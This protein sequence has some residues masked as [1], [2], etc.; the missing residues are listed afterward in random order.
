MQ[1][2]YNLTPLCSDTHFQLQHYRYLPRPEVFEG[3]D[4]GTIV[5]H[6]RPEAMLAF[7]ESIHGI[8]HDMTLPMVHNHWMQ[9]LAEFVRLA[10]ESTTPPPPVAV[11]K[12]ADLW[13]KERWRTT[14]VDGANVV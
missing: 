12:V 5:G 7:Y 3:V 1:T 6:V 13:K 8:H 14:M 10:I 2:Y 4:T 11:P 9:P